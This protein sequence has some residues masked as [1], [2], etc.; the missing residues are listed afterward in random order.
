MFSSSKKS[1]EAQ[2]KETGAPEVTPTFPPALEHFL[3]LSPPLPPAHLPGETQCPI[4]RPE[5]HRLAPVFLPP[6][7]VRISKHTQVH[8]HDTH[9]SS[10]ACSSLLEM[11][12]DGDLYFSCFTT[13]VVRDCYGILCFFTQNS[14]VV[15][16][17]VSKARNGSRDF[18][19]K[20][21]AKL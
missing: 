15:Y 12:H 16:C 21:A 20:N 18:K 8:A 4:S 14:R 1:A 17:S 10:E 5:T 19:T 7:G 2:S 11:R 13:T 3:C 9:A 6:P